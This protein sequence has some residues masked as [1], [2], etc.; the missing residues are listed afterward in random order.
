MTVELACSQE[1]RRVSQA[2][3]PA[4]PA[5]DIGIKFPINAAFIGHSSPL[6]SDK[7][8]SQRSLGQFPMA[9][10]YSVPNETALLRVLWHVIG[11]RMRDLTLKQ[12][13]AVPCPTCGVAPGRR[14]LLHSGAPRSEPHVDRKLSA[15]E[16]IVRR[17]EFP[18]ILDVDKSLS[19]QQSAICAGKPCYQQ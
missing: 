6:A 1:S 17:K 18:E 2:S 14:C 16:A 11:M 7:P 13:T 8:C 3:T 5:P 19:G 4:R 9:R 15:A 10:A 12:L